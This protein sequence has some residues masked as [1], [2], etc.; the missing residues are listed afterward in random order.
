M[1]RNEI[2]R[3]IGLTFAAMWVHGSLKG[4]EIMQY[5][6][7]IEYLEESI[8]MHRILLVL[9]SITGIVGWYL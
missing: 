2:L 6:Q 3:T 7:R 4:L 9:V 8:L 1:K 5:H